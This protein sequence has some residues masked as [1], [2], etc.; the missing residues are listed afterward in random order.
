MSQNDI[1]QTKFGDQIW[2]TGILMLVF[3]SLYARYASFNSKG[4]TEKYK[5]MSQ[6]LFFYL[7]K[8]L[9]WSLYGEKKVEMQVEGALF[10]RLWSMPFTEVKNHDIVLV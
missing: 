2:A 5:W 4:W 9:L 6:L 1:R 7:D 3:Q 10:E 8:A